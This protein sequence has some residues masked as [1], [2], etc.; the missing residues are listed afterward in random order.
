MLCSM[1]CYAVQFELFLSIEC[2]GG[3]E[4]ICALKW[5]NLQWYNTVLYS[6][7]SKNL[8]A[9]LRSGNDYGTTRVVT[10]HNEGGYVSCSITRLGGRKGPVFILQAVCWCTFYYE[11]LT[12]KGGQASL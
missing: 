3:I 8:K 7:L 2:F 11:S 5:T 4:S 9:L 1:L 6:T 12:P 10:N